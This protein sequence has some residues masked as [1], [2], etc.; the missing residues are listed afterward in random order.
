[1]STSANCQQPPLTQTKYFHTWFDILRQSLSIY[2]HM[3]HL[4]LAKTLSCSW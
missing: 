1:M 4:G 3:N 2:I